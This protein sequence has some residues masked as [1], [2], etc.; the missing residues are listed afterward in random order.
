MSRR[1]ATVF[2]VLVLLCGFRTAQAASDRTTDSASA[3]TKS[4]RTAG[5]PTPN[6]LFIILDDVGVDQMR[7]F[8]YGGL[9]PVSAPNTPNI[10]VI[11]RAGVRFR[12]VWSMPECSP[13]R[14][15]F[16]EGRYPLRT[17][18]YTAILATD[19]ANSQLSPY[20]V[21]TPKLLRSVGYTNALFGKFHLAGPTYNPYE[22]GTPHAAG[23]DYF[24]GFLEGAPYPIDGTIGGQFPDGRYTCGFVPPAADGGADTGGCR[25]ANGSCV[26]I[27]RDPQDPAPGRSCLQQGGLFVPN[28]QCN[29]PPPFALNFGQPN[30]Y[31]VWH[32]VINQPDGTVTQFP[33]TD[34]S[35]RQY[36]S[37]Q[38]IQSAVDWINM[39]NQQQQPWMATV[40]FA[41]IHTPYQQPPRSLLPST[42][43][44]G[45]GLSCA[46]QNNEKDLRIISNQMLEAADTHIGQLLVQT[47]LATYNPNGSL[48]YQPEQTNTMVVIIGDN[49]TYAVSVKL[50]FDPNLSKGTVYQ[51]GVW[52][53][54]IV[55]GPLVAAP[56]REVT[57]MVNIADLFQLWGEIVGID[58]HQVDSH[59]ID[60][61]SM[62]PYLTNPQQGEIR[63]VNFAE[64]SSNIHLNNVAPSPC[65]LSVT[66]PPTCVQIFPQK[67]LCEFEGGC[68]YGPG[69]GTQ[70][71]P[72]QGTQFPSCCAVRAAGIFPG[73]VTLLPDSAY[74]TRNDNY[75]LIRLEKPNCSGGEPTPE[76]PDTTFN[77]FYSINER[78]V[79]PRIDFPGLALCADDAPSQSQKCP[80]GLNQD[81][82]NNYNALT[83]AMNNILSSQPPCPGDGNEDLMVNQLDLVL[84]NYYS[85]FN[86]GGSSWYDFNF[87]GRTDNQDEAIIE[88]HLG[89]NCH[90]EGQPQVAAQRKP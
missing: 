23:F 14:V 77:E 16:F 26:V 57:S 89:T 31:Y 45:S 7:I 65:V 50:P 21:T 44:E 30:A 61:E 78:P 6:I 19:L 3:A 41:N 8:G 63:Q 60:S 43:I 84:W 87:D 33:L 64:T 24:D 1:T 79:V 32:R 25:F 37:N 67:K 76:P 74:A 55:A 72:S 2:A 47:G 70:D 38:T 68:W 4:V 81:E 90:Q 85:L 11:A 39:Q 71:C 54:L 17:N 49:G 83:M 42:E 86:G 73:G 46:N 20:E 58:V 75:K 18:I 56:D 28:T 59:I 53:P 40:S 12:N 10:D 48:N 82:L 62:L 27:S 66:A 15:M 52:V 51:T 35:A 5:A 36:V 80:M 22:Y 88:Q 34:P 13:S 9:T 69:G 29:M